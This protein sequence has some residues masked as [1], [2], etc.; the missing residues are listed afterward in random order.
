MRIRYVSTAIA[1]GNS[2]IAENDNINPIHVP[3]KSHLRRYENIISGHFVWYQIYSTVAMALI[4]LNKCHWNSVVYDSL[5]KTNNNYLQFKI[6]RYI[7]SIWPG[8]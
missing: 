5:Q 8:C 2:M 4:H 6:L 1:E 3:G 7:F